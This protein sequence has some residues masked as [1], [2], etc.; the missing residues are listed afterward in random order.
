MRVG[1][2]D[3]SVDLDVL[4]QDFA[5]QLQDC[6][7]KGVPEWRR[8]SELWQLEGLGSSSR[9][10][11]SHL[12]RP[13]GGASLDDKIQRPFLPVDV[14]ING[15]AADH[16]TREVAKLMS[17]SNARLVPIDLDTAACS[18]RTNTNF[19]FPRCT[20]DH[21]ENLWY[22][23]Q[24][25][26]RIVERGYPLADASDYPSVS[27]TRTQ[28]AGYHQWAKTRALSMY[29]R[30][31][32]NLEKQ[33]QVPL[34]RFLRELPEFVVWRGQDEVD[35]AMTRLLESNP[36]EVLSVDFTSFD[37]SVPFEVITRVF[38]IIGS[39]FAA[40]SKAHVDFVAEAFMR[41]GSFAPVTYY[42]GT[43]RTCGIP[44]G[45][46]LTSPVGGL[47]NL[48]VFHY[49]AFRS[50]K[51]GRMKS[52]CVAGDDGVMTFSGIDS[53]DS[54][55]RVLLHD[56]GMVVKMEPS[57]NLVARDQVKF[58][59]MDHHLGYRVKGICV[60]VRPVLRALIG[61]TGHERAPK[62]RKCYADDGTLLQ[63]EGAY[64]T[65][66]WLQQLESCRFHPG[67][68]ELAHWYRAQDDMLDDAL[69]AIRAGSDVVRVAA[70]LLNDDGDD[71]G[72]LSVKSLQQ[73]VI[74][75]LLTE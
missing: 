40:S 38:A 2:D 59:Q 63:W 48:W 15:D 66:R 55:S 33:L 54:L 74:V 35:R 67:V 36:G 30:S 19:G 45:S 46:A 43:E 3:P 61:M 71:L 44:S 29:C 21:D 72:K 16:A 53:I 57:K 64:N 7:L 18:F 28:A 12:K 23:Y 5:R 52:A 37:A 4:R 6:C 17:V 51:G 42:H 69:E 25:S 41:S 60:G 49:A 56:L 10:L 31:V 75:K 58:L 27:T 24:E 47:C 22:Y 73:S 39:W 8:Q 14:K 68:R 9:R 13:D 65:Y 32:A 11:P 34:F 20:S 1:V 70:A 50:K 62:Q 26:V